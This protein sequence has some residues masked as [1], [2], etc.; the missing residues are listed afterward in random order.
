MTTATQPAV[1]LTKDAVTLYDIEQGV[2]WDQMSHRQTL[3]ELAG[4]K[5]VGDTVQ[6][7]ETTDRNG[8]P[9]RVVLQ[10]GAEAYYSEDQGGIYEF[11]L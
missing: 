6:E 5:S 3:A 2:V 8:H 4:S 1:T 10:V 7:Y 9:M 11:T